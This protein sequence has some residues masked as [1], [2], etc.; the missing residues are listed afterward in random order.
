ME[1]LLIKSRRK[2]QAVSDKFHRYLFKQININSQL[3]SVLGARGVGKTTLLLQLAKQ[4][5]KE[6]LYVALD[7]LFFTENTLYSLAENFSQIGGEL[8]LLDEVH[9]YP[10]WSRELKLIFDDLPN[11][12]VIFTSSSVLDIYKG[13][14]DLSRRALNYHLK[15]LSFREYLELYHQ[16]KLPIISL[17]DITSNHTSLSDD[18]S[19]RFKPLKYLSSYYESGIYPYFKNDKYEYY[20]QLNNTINLILDV[21]LQSIENI[22]Y[23][24][25]AKFK[26]LLYVLAT[27]VPYT[28]NISKL[29]DK[30]SINRN[31][32]VQALNLLHKAELL[33]IVYKQNKSISTLTKPDKIWLHNTNLAYAI[34]GES[35][36]VG[37][38]R[39][40]FFLQ[41]TSVTH[42]VTL[43]LKGDFYIDN[44]YTFEVG[45]KNKT[46]H[47]IQNL[48]HAF[49]VKDNIESGTM[50]TIPLWLFGLL[51]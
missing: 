34:S 29:A 13:E 40:T 33:H 3:V 19:G 26:R 7:D 44:K 35:P 18:L 31:A 51:Y 2:I 25:I 43:P 49:I 4:S 12:K 11:L 1:K 22:E 10:N 47:Q 32:L 17:D 46:Q 27:N 41:H 5:D 14:S 50:N 45:G 15:E 36:N 16:I 42:K 24:N 9:K 39:E 37:N 38:L 23:S 48:D 8:L 21:D 28:P 20:Q 6:V 30:I